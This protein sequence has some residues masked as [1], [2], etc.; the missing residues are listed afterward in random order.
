[1]TDVQKVRE[2]RLR[3]VARRRGIELLKSRRRDV[4][5]SDYGSWMAV[6]ISTNSLLVE[7]DN[8]DELE[9]WLNDN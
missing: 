6:D 7:C 2:N 8:V 9:D 4:R 1:M 5:A 3:R